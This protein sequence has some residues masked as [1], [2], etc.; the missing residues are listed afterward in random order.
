[1]ILLTMSISEEILSE[2][3][4]LRDSA[5]MSNKLTWN[6]SLVDSDQ[7]NGYVAAP[8]RPMKRG[9]NTI[10]VQIRL[11]KNKDTG[12]PRGYA[13]ILYERDKDMKGTVAHNPTPPPP[14]VCFRNLQMRVWKKDQ[15][16]RKK[17][18]AHPPP[19]AALMSM[20]TI[21]RLPS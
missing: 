13:F 20:H 5:T 8:V 7:L 10:C 14:L 6:G 15:E 21:L 12:K 11:V 1:M 17:R 4:L 19:K 9:S 2:P 3:F 16:S 18:N